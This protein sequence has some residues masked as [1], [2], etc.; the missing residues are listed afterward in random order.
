MVRAQTGLEFITGITIMLVI[1]VLAIGVYSY[2]TENRIIDVSFA[3]H[4]CYKVSEGID[5]A[6]IGGNG[7]SINISIP[8]RVYF[9]DLNNVS[10]SNNYT[11]TVEWESGIKACSIITR[12][13]TVQSVYPGKFSATNMDGRIY[14]TSIKTN[15][16]QYSS[17]QAAL[18]SSRFINGATANLT[19]SYANGTILKGPLTRT[20]S[21]NTIYYT[22]NTTGVQHGNY[23][24]NVADN[25]YKNLNAEKWVEII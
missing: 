3:E 9:D 12:N 21:S 10:I 4:I 15:S 24:I 18:I 14:L 5:A 23:R 6:V 16:T 19:I 11:A 7:F 8:Y 20:A 1:Y 17:G 22:W 13:I 25:T 2:Y